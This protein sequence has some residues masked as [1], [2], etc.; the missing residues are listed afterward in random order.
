[1]AYGDAPASSPCRSGVLAAVSKNARDT[2]REMRRRAVL[3][4]DA[5]RAVHD[6]ERH[7]LSFVRLSQ[8]AKRVGEVVE[9]INSI[10]DQSELLAARA[11]IAATPANS[12]AAARTVVSMAVAPAPAGVDPESSATQPHDAVLRFLA[13]EPAR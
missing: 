2:V 10:T 11:V 7:A 12:D 9:L 1:M 4:S 8:A 13:R 3:R 6:S 5:W